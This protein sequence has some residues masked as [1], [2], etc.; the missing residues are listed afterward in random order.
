MTSV[1]DAGQDT[2]RAH[3][4]PAADLGRLEYVQVLTKVVNGNRAQ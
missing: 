4:R 2:Q 1:D 3:L